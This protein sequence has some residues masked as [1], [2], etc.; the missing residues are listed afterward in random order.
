MDLSQF[1]KELWYELFQFVK[2]EDLLALTECSKMLNS[3]INESVLSKKFILYL[4]DE[5][6][7]NT[8]RNFIKAVIEKYRPK[9]HEKVL[10][11]SSVSLQELTFNSCNLKLSVL[12][13]ILSYTSNVQ[14]L[15]L[16]YVRIDEDELTNE[17][18]LPCLKNLNLSLQE[19]SPVLFSILKQCEITSL[20]I[21]LYG[22]VPYSD[23]TPLVELLSTQNGL[24]RLKL[25]G[26]YETNLFLFN[27]K[28]RVNF[29]LSSFSLSNSDLEEY[30]YLESFLLS[31]C[32]SLEELYIERLPEVEYSAILNK[33][34]NL[35]KLNIKPSG[36]NLD[37]LET[38]GIQ[39]LILD[40]GECPN[41]LNEIVSKF[42]SVLTLSL[43]S[44]H[45]TTVLSTIS[46]TMPN[47]NSITIDDGVVDNLVMKNIKKVLIRSVN[48]TSPAFTKF[49][50]D[51]N[52]IEVLFLEVDGN[53]SDTILEVITKN[54]V[55]LKILSIKND[56]LLTKRAFE[57]IQAN[58]PNLKTFEM[59][60]WNQKFNK[61]DMIPLFEM[62]G[63]SFYC[64][65]C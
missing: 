7:V 5:T 28:E 29:K 1:P 39:E 24:K 35:K 54:L 42:P 14:K 40:A 23:F 3:V 19:T 53:F 13:D 9:L 46:K 20:D 37:S 33:C 45:D 61:D 15:E 26:F 48:T 2:A 11:A 31:Q 12:A 62:K 60:Y 63:L 6:L 44:C 25:K 41:N 18:Q 59:Q 32:S 49:F 16:D 4:R 51:N 10:R 56:C 47:L 52:T 38:I 64:K 58:C 27:I 55:E 50:I 57:I 34:V 65:D 36:L 21:A 43:K 8:T 17:Q 30:H 22:D